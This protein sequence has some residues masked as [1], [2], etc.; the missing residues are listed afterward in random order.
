MFSRDRRPTRCWERI[1]TAPSGEGGFVAR[2]LAARGAQLGDGI[3]I[4]ELGRRDDRPRLGPDVPEKAQ[5]VF[6]LGCGHD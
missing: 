6:L 3:G 2:V 1:Q 5:G 4:R